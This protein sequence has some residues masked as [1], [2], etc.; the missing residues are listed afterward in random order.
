MI[1]MPPSPGGVETAHMVSCSSMAVYYHKPVLVE[2]IF[3]DGK[4]VRSEFMRGKRKMEGARK[5]I[6]EK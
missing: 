1:P 6:Y 2:K 3:F 5:K 4:F